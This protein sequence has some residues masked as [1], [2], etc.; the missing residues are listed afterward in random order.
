MKLKTLK[1]AKYAHGKTVERV[2]KFFNL[3]RMQYGPG[4]EEQPLYVI[5][6]DFVAQFGTVDDY[7]IHELSFGEADEGRFTWVNNSES[8]KLDWFLD[9][10]EIFQKSKVL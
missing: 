6:P 3:K 10:I 2:L 8:F 4:G 1:E 9:N 5:K 7:N